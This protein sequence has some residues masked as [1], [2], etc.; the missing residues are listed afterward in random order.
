[1]EQLKAVVAVNATLAFARRE[2]HR[3]AFRLDDGKEQIVN[4]NERLNEQPANLYS[5]YYPTV[6]RRVTDNTVT[7][8]GKVAAG[9]HTLTIRP[10]EPGTVFEKI[11]L[12][13]GGYRKTYLYGE[14]SP[15]TRQP[16]Q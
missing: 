1:M 8:A 2:G 15:V 11:V 3:Y 16:A 9:L 10:L 12:D 4:F 14:E 5:V 7:F 13:C 6:A